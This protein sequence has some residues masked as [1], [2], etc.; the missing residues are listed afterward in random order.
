MD[1]V[2]SHVCLNLPFKLTTRPRIR[3]F[4]L[5]FESHDGMALVPILKRSASL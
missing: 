1:E 5:I 4:Y 2:S 3:S